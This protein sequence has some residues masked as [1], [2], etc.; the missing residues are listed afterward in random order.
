MRGQRVVTVLVAGL[1]GFGCNVFTDR[2]AGPSLVAGYLY[3]G[4]AYP[5]GN[6]EL[7]EAI[8]RCNEWHDCDYTGFMDGLMSASSDSDFVR[9]GW[10]IRIE[11]LRSWSDSE[12]APVR[13]ELNRRAREAGLGPFV[14]IGADDE[15]P[16]CAG[17]PDCLTVDES[18]IP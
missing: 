13:S 5:H 17:T 10:G 6:I 16:S 18:I 11:F 8:T 12:L 15:W 14:F 7:H 9:G 2:T 1:A 3:V 4:D